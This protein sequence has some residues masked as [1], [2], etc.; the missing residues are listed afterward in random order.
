[1]DFRIRMIVIRIEGVGPCESA[2]ERT[3]RFLD[4]LSRL[5]IHMYR[6]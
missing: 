3:L 2:L 6:Q 4:I 5:M 1:M